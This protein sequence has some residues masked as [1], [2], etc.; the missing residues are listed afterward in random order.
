MASR[1]SWLAVVARPSFLVTGS[2]PC[3]CVRRRVDYVSFIL[4][5]ATRVETRKKRCIHRTHQPGPARSLDTSSSSVHTLLELIE[6]AKV[7]RDELV[8]LACRGM[9]RAKV[10]SIRHGRAP[11]VRCNDLEDR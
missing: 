5:L 4:L 10:M 3:H 8:K 1:G 9:G 11:T 7:T 2:T 6:G